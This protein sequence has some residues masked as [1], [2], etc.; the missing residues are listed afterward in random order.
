MAPGPASD[1]F[2][3][4]KPHHY[5]RVTGPWFSAFRVGIRYYLHG[6]PCGFHGDPTRECR[7]TPGI[8]RKR[9]CPRSAGPCGTSARR[10]PHGGLDEAGERTLEMAVRRMGFSVRAHDRIL[11]VARTIAKAVQCRGGK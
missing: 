3:R 10:R 4:G 7:C 5:Q 2:G 8:I 6:C 1:V 11:K 9:T